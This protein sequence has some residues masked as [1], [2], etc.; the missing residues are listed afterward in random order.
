[1]PRFVIHIVHE[2]AIA[3]ALEGIRKK[4]QVEI[5]SLRK[6]IHN[7]RRETAFKT[8]HKQPTGIEIDIGVPAIRG[9]Q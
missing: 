7:V 6:L 9:P 8:A 4:I 1:M 3:V 2:Y 5:Q